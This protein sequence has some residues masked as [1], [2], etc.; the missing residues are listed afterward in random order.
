MYSVHEDEPSEID[1][2]IRR[3]SFAGF[4]TR[5]LS[6]RADGS[7]GSPPVRVG[8]CQAN[9]GSA[10]MLV[11]FCIQKRIENRRFT[12]CVFKASLCTGEGEARRSRI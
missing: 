6:S 3:L 10:E 11:F 8:R 2:E 1:E 7:W 9:R 5:K 12:F 4:R